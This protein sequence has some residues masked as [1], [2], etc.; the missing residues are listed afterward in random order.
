MKTIIITDEEYLDYADRDESHF[1]DLKSR[2]ISPQKIQRAAV[3][4]SNADGGEIVVGIKDK[5]TGLPP[6]DRWE[7]IPNI[8]TLNDHL[9]VLFAVDPPLEIQYEIIKRDSCDGYALRI[10]I[11]KGSLVCTTADGKVYVRQGSQSLP[12]QSAERIQQLTFAK[13]AKSYEDMCIEECAPEQIVDSEE[14]ASFLLDYSPKT[15]PLEFVIN[16]NLLDYKTWH[17]RIASALLFHDIPSA[18]VPRKCAIKI[19]RYE[20]KEDDPERDH[21]ANQY[22]IEG[23]SYKI[24]HES[25]TKITEIMSAIDVWTADGRKRL[26]Y[27]PEAIW[28]TVVN[29]VIHRDYSISDDIQILI[30][31]DRIEILSPGKLPGYVNVE[32]ILD[33]RF[34]RNPKMVR[35]LNRYKDPPNRD[36]G[37]GLNTTFQK[38]KEFGL[39]NPIIEEK[40]NYLSVILPHAP[41]AAPTVAI[42]KF[43]ES[44]EEITNK[45]ARDITGIKSENLMKIEFYKLRDEGHIELVPGKTSGPRSAWHLTNKGKAYNKSKKTN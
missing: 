40:G 29:A 39:K 12:L 35:T 2:E 22:T 18:V 43:L 28:E 11:E 20:T 30:F 6:E 15:D 24:I 10:L 7:A 17:P 14:L 34:S 3:A 25:V 21:L 44:H 16:Q 5:K 32:N 38:M 33:A 31:D 1:F 23:P 42:M 26:E 27:P 45:Q 8:E 19:T 41:L 13:G 9:Q 37:E 36:L 4:F